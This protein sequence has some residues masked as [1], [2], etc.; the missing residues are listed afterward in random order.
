MYSFS[1]QG[2]LSGLHID[3]SLAEGNATRFSLHAQLYNNC[4]NALYQIV[5][6]VVMMAENW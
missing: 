6:I 4:D 2:H 1:L 3:A 5:H